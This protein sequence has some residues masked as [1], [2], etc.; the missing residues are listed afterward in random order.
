MLCRVNQDDGQRDSIEPY[1]RGGV[2]VDAEFD[3]GFQSE[4]NFYTGFSENISEGGVF[5][6]TYEKRKIGEQLAVRFTLP[7][8]DTPIE[9]T[10]QVMW[11]REGDEASGT[12][13][14]YGLQFVQLSDQAQELVMRFIKK[15]APMFYDP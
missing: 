8:I 10:A 1:R 4:S 12:K 7:G 5:V 14:G 6:A 13:P 9:A 11:A 2:R 3:I 15:R